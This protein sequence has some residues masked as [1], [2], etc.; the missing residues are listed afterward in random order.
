MTIVLQVLLAVLVVLALYAAYANHAYNRVLPQSRPC[1]D[2]ATPAHV[3]GYDLYYREL[4]TDK[5]LPPV[6]LV[7][8]GPGHSSLSF[9][10]GFDFLAEQTRVIFYDQRGSGNSQIKPNPEDYTIEQLVEELET[11][12][13]DVVKADKVILIGH[14]FGSA[15]VQRYALKYPQHVE[16]MVIAGGIRINNGMNNRFIWKWFGGLLYSTALGFPPTDSKSADAWFTKSSEKDNPQ[17]LFDKTKIDLLKDTGTVSFAPWREISF[18]LVGYDYKKE[19][20]QLQV[21]T[22]FIYG[23]ADS[24]YTGKPVAD[25]LCA[26]LPNCQSVEFTQSAPS[27]IQRL[28]RADF[29]HLHAR[30]D[31]SRR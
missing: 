25:E 21:P 15:L 7:H 11:L 17:R 29:V 2:C 18:S 22:L 3:N 10:N 13:R 5:G 28:H 12:R 24:Q 30:W 20:S 31:S 16:K 26:T 14:S 8:G 1:V 19:L 23:A 27:F 6:I 9:K 4:G